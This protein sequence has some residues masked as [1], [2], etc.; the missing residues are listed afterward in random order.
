MD[1]SC[2]YVHVPLYEP[3]EYAKPEESDLSR[4]SDDM[5]DFFKNAAKAS[6][7]GCNHMPEK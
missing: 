2:G 7:F 5:Q 6:V 4:F 3:A 1:R